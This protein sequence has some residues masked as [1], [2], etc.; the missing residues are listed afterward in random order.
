MSRNKPLTAIE[1]PLRVKRRKA[2]TL[3][4]LMIVVAIIAIVSAILIP[5]F[6]RARAR[7]MKSSIDLETS[8]VAQKAAHPPGEELKR[9]QDGIFPVTESADISIK[10]ASSHKRIGM[11]VYT[12]YEARYKGSFILSTPQETG[13]RVILDFR[14]PEYTTE[15]RD[16]S[17]KLSSNGTEYEPDNVIYDGQGIFWAGRPIGKDPGTADGKGPSNTEANKPSELSWTAPVTADVTFVSQ[18]RDSF[19]YMLPPSNRVK[20]ISITLDME[21]NP[22]FSIPD[23]AL[24]PTAM[25]GNTITWKFDNLVTYRPIVIELPAAQS[26]IGRV[27]LLCKL[28]AL[29]VFLFGAGF[30]YLAELYQPGGLHRFRWAHFLLLALTY[31]LFFIIFAVLGFRGDVS[32]MN[33]MLLAAALSLPFLV[34]HVS[35]II[36][37]R[38]ALTRTLPLAIFTLGLAVNGVYGGPLRDYFYIAS[39]LLIVGFATFTLKKLLANR[40]KWTETLEGNV[41]E[42][43]KKL[44]EDIARARELDR[45]AGELTAGIRHGRSP[46]LEKELAESRKQLKSSLDEYDKLPVELSRMRG[47]KDFYS[48]QDMRTSIENRINACRSSLPFSIES[49][50]EDINSLAS[51]RGAKGEKPAPGGGIHCM[52]CGQSGEDTPY[53]PYCGTVRPTIIACRNCGEN[54]RLPLHLMEGH[55]LPPSVCCPACG[56]ENLLAGGETPEGAP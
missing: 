12:R 8:K 10:I 35:W 17:L 19:R 41:E 38:F 4:E 2:F 14:F 30:W 11:D 9:P 16:V 51:D 28:V 49:V 40:E 44:G 6:L 20:A 18:G 42:D 33:A 36:D 37:I 26:P 29:A 32:T 46:E 22:S 13:K 21:G 45:K 54:I 31:S 39:A 27:L 7:A 47:V 43:L 23:Y 24:Q 55:A 48:R 50:E 1:R 56:T 52:Q 15:A 3:I 53:C 34:F 25:A 5:N